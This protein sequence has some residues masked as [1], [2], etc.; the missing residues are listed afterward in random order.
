MR[1]QKLHFVLIDDDLEDLEMLEFGIKE[2]MSDAEVLCYSNAHKAL[3]NLVSAKK[4]NIP[5]LVMVDYNMPKLQGLD[6]IKLIRDDAKLKNLPVIMYST[7]VRNINKE[8]QQK[9]NFLAMTKSNSLDELMDCV[10]TMIDI[11]Q[12]NGNEIGAD[13]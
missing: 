10:D 8:M 6:F 4:S 1:K 5:N 11:A 2:K 7:D 9:W 3:E 12:S 13:A